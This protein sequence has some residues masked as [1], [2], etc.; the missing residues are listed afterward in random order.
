MTLKT[1]VCF[2]INI[3]ILFLHIID[4]IQR[5]HRI[6][7]AHLFYYWYSAVVADPLYP[8]PSPPPTRCPSNVINEVR[9]LVSLLPLSLSQGLY[10]LFSTSFQMSQTQPP[11]PTQNKE[12]FGSV[13]ILRPSCG[14]HSVLLIGTELQPRLKYLELFSLHPFIF[15]ALQNF[16]I[17]FSGHAF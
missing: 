1:E 8:H 15:E 4:H 13:F 9:A 5:L 16:K 12:I 17:Y 7:V 14:R 2:V 11:P 3:F 10:F 6:H